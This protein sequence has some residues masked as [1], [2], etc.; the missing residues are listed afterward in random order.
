MSNGLTNLL[1]EEHIPEMAIIVYSSSENKVYL[2]RRDIT[3]GK[4]GAGKPLSN[5]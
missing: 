2:E 1:K 3:D 5:H 4:M